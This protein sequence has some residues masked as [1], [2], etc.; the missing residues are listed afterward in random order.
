MTGTTATAAARLRPGSLIGRRVL[1]AAGGGRVEIP[2]PDRLV[3]LQ[4]RRFAGCPFCN[5]HLRAYELRHGEIAAAGIREVVVFRSTEEQLQ[6]HHGDLPYDIV[7]DPG[8]RLYRAFGV[9]AGWRSV[10][11]PRAALKAL[12]HIVRSLFREGIGLPA[13]GATVDG[14]LGMP[15]DFLIGTDGHVIACGYWDSADEGWPVDE[16]LALARANPPVPA[17]A[18]RAA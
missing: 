10:L 8:G 1:V 9:E 14:F 3:H 18:G 6:R 11:N 15:A 7:L 12:P 13:K 16:M 2:D 17:L 5:M 4:F